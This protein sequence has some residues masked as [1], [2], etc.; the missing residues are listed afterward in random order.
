MIILL[1]GENSVMPRGSVLDPTW[2]QVGKLRGKG[3]HKCCRSKS[4]VYH[5]N[6]CTYIKQLTSDD[7]SDLKEKTNG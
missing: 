5:K 1:R 3:Y 6:D 7:Y 4:A 2:V